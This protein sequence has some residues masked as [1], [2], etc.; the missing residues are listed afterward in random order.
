MQSACTGVT[1][2]RLDEAL[3]V[4]RLSAADLNVGDRPEVLTGPHHLDE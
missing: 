3:S 2:G 4:G 1:D